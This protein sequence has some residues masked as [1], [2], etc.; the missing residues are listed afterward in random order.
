[1]IIIPHLHQV[2]FPDGGVTAFGYFPPPLAQANIHGLQ[3]F[4][5]KA[6]SLQDDISFCSPLLDCQK[7]SP[8][9]YL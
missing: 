5:T 1:M 6:S 7:K 8:P 4:N 9:F 3:I 2:F